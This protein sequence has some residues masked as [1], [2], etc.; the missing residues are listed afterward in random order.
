MAL[1]TGEADRR[2]ASDRSSLF[3]AHPAFAAFAEVL[4]VLRTGR[5]LRVSGEAATIGVV[6][7]FSTRKLSTQIL[8]SQLAI[9]T[10]TVLIGFVLFARV[11]RTQLDRQ[12]EDRAASI[13]ETVAGVPDIQRCVATPRGR[14]TESVQTVASRIQTETHAAYI[15][16]I[17]MNRVRH[18]HPI[19][20]LIGQQVS[21]PII[22]ADGRTHVGIDH[23]ATGPSANAKAP[24]YDAD[25]HM[26][27]E[28]SVG[29]TENSVSAALW[30]ELPTYAAWLTVALAAGAA[31]SWLLAHRLKQKTFGLELD[32]IAQLL[33]EREATLHGIREGVLGFDPSGRMSVVNDEA[34][35]LLGDIAAPLGSRLE[36]VLPPGRLRAVLTGAVGGPDEVVITDDYCLTVNRMPIALNGKPHGAVVTL[37]DRTE[38]SGLLRELDG[39]RG[40]TDALRAQQHEFSNRLHAVTGLLELGDVDEALHYLVEL[41]GGAAEFADSLRARIGSPLIIGLLLGKAAEASERGVAFQITEDTWLGDSTQRIQALTTILGNLIDNAFEAVAGAAGSSRV[42][43]Q[44]ID[45]D[46]AISIRVSDNG[47]GIPHGDRELIY[48]DGYTTKP[49][50]GLQQRGLGLALVHRLVQRLRGTITVSDGPNP[51]FEIWLPA[52]SPAPVPSGAAHP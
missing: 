24:M 32:A 44:I 46:G 3:R 21:E 19:Q 28:V 27:G 6:V 10:A 20:A 14:C 33:Q 16:V 4:R 39:T 7:R 34:R 23:G 22:T 42:V 25:N 5:W 11:E 12:Y 45:D 15:V 41:R 9:L 17:D 13:A 30:R 50:R 8:V 38:M 52:V 1:L 49:G 18:S 36:E 35:R 26:I 51:A 40:L 43:V 48:H 47:P 31:A 2:R 37:R 29:I